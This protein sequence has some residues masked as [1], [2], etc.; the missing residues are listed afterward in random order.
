MGGPLN[1]LLAPGNYTL[2]YTL[3]ANTTITGNLSGTIPVT[4]HAG[5]SLVVD[6]TKP[7]EDLARL[8]VDATPC[9]TIAIEA[10]NYTRQTQGTDIVPLTLPAGTYTI[11]CILDLHGHQL[12]QGPQPAVNKTVTLTPHDSQL[13]TFPG[14]DEALATLVVEAPPGAVAIIKGP[15]GETEINIVEG[16]TQYYALPGEYTV[17]IRY[18]EAWKA[19]EKRLSFSLSPGDVAVASLTREELR[20]TPQFY[21]LAT[22]TALAGVAPALAYYI[23]EDTAQAR[24]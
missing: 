22:G 4:V 17:T 1:L 21:M 16:R 3:P 20:P 12:L 14:I 9:S 8:T 11:T 19:G 7:L 13:L 24:H 6:L 5:D 15:W 18:S 23:S 10:L 2:N